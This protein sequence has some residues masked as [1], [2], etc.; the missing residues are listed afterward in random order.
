MNVFFIEDKVNVDIKKMA[1]LVFKF[2]FLSV[3]VALLQVAAGQNG[4]QIIN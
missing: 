4:K 2:A 1:S 3:C